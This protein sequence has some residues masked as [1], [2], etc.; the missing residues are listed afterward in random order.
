MRFF[1]LVAFLFALLALAACGDGTAQQQPPFRPSTP[2]VQATALPGQVPC[3]QTE[4]IPFENNVILLAQ[5][6]I[7]QTAV[8]SALR[9]EAC[10][11]PG[12]TVDGYQWLSFLNGVLIEITQKFPKGTVVGSSREFV[13]EVCKSAAKVLLQ[14]ELV[15][16][17]RKIIWLNPI[18]Q[19]TRQLPGPTPNPKEP[20][21]V[22]CPLPP[23]GPT[24]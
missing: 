1:V 2:N 19:G 14:R 15:D 23:K 17:N 8:V 22:G 24:A 10:V 18:I 7:A 16:L 21:F 12:V 11:S 13:D 3:K 9:F 20:P 6:E 5:L 4:R